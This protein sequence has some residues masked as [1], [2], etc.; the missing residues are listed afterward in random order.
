MRCGC[1]RR[2]GVGGEKVWEG[3]GYRRR[4]GVGGCVLP[5]VLD[6]QT[7]PHRDDDEGVLVW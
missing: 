1:R 7:S 4:E 2:E 6:F 3:R 5:S